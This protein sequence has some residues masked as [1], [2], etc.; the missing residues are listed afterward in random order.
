MKIVLPMKPVW[1]VVKQ[2]ALSGMASG[3]TRGQLP[4]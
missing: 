2:L 4:L 3:A 1:N